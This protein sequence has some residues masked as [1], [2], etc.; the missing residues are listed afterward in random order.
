MNT[1]NNPKKPKG[2]GFSAD[3]SRIGKR[4]LGAR[5]GGFVTR[6]VDNMGNDSAV[7]LAAAIS[8][9]V[10]LS[11]FPLLL[12]IVALLGFFLPY[13][14]VEDAISRFLQSHLS[15]LEKILQPNI[16]SI[17]H[18]RGPLAIIGILGFF[19]SGSAMFSAISVAV[20]RAW[21]IDHPRK[22]A[23][24]KLRELA[25]SLSTTLLLVMSMAGT[26]FLSF[27]SP[28]SALI[29]KVAN[30]M[31]S[32]VLVFAVFALIYKWV[33]NTKTYWR[34]IWPGALLGAVFFE[35]A[36]MLMGLYFA[37]FTNF[38]LAYSSIASIVVLLIW[39]YLSALILVVGAEVSFEY[40][41][42]RLKFPLK[43]WK[44][45]PVE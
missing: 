24:R 9:Y 41:R 33:P 37:A 34:L 12:G 23:L 45:M 16:A 10:I 25:M 4:L 19:W 32:V 29:Q 14:S 13:T 36:R 21:E 7:D 43:R 30:S 40:S 26:A 6:V 39:V 2:H 1:T 15:G 22:I 31:L 35:L 5:F 27:V 8:Y 20:N 11:L 18:A 44:L 28:G 38:E 3:V 17:M 42:R